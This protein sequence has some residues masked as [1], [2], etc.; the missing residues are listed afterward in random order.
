MNVS[1]FISSDNVNK[2]GRNILQRRLS[3]YTGCFVEVIVVEKFYE[4]HVDECTGSG[5]ENI[6]M[7]VKGRGF[8][9]C[10]GRVIIRHLYLMLKC[11][12]FLSAKMFSLIRIKLRVMY[13]SVSD[14]GI[15]GE[16]NPSA[17]I[18]SRT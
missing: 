1:Q 8:A 9:V 11:I 2:C 10:L 6:K 14:A 12:N 5:R 16:R 15:L 17:P 18:R 4:E 7:A 3:K 13:L